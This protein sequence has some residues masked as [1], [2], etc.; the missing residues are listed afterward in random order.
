MCRS[1]QRDDTTAIR[2]QKLVEERAE[3]R[4]KLE[5]TAASNPS[6]ALSSFSPVD[7]PNLNGEFTLEEWELY[8]HRL[9]EQ[10]PDGA[11]D[12]VR[13]GFNGPVYHATTLT[14]FRR[15]RGDFI[16]CSPGGSD[17]SFRKAWLSIS[18]S[19]AADDH[20]RRA[21]ALV[22]SDCQLKLP[23][24]PPLSRVCRAQMHSHGGAR[25][26][27]CLDGDGDHKV[28]VFQID[29]HHEQYYEL[30]PFQHAHGG[31][32]WDN[33]IL[34]QA[35]ISDRPIRVGSH[36]GPVATWGGVVGVKLVEVNLTKRTWR[37]IYQ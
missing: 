5:E 35:M 17:G 28:Y 16:E 4:R 12:F 3:K 19:T 30:R 32:N 29:H 7:F 36:T 34:K 15:W 14:A 2:S 24:R 10:F 1:C 6:A 18:A 21:R 9:G 22:S 37:Y 23:P 8:D 31:F 27:L 26:K 11:D 13:L 20:V 33:K 25:L